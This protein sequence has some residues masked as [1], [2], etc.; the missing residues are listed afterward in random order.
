[1]RAQRAF[2]SAHV[3]C[4]VRYAAHDLVRTVSRTSAPTFPSNLIDCTPPAQPNAYPLVRRSTI[5]RPQ[6]G[7][8]R[9]ATYSAR[10]SARATIVSVGLMKPLV[11]K[12][13]LPATNRLS[14]EKT[15]HAPSTTPFVG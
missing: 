8:R 6:R 11:V 3:K 4:S 1:M 5:E 13:E 2:R 10:R 7:Q 15:L 14:R 9:R 12:T